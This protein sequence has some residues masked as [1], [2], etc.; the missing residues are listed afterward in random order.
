M[1]V[2]ERAH[3]RDQMLQVAARLFSERGY[4]G[5]SMQDL[6]EDLGMLR[7]SLYAHIESKE[8]LLFHIV[9]E[10][11]DRFIARMSEVA[12]S[13]SDPFEKLRAGLLA[14]ITTVAEHLDA[15]T[16]F[17][18]DWR[19]L[20]PA[21]KKQ[22]GKKRSRYEQLVSSIIEEGIK[23]GSFRNDLDPRFAALTFLSTV[24]WLYQWYDPKG[25]LD[26]AGIADKFSEIL[27]NGF[28]PHTRQRSHR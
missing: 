7:G 20:S 4:H 2:T 14:H 10:G 17:L 5:T 23:S 15:S 6:A 18:N 9:D 11:A 27:I 8:D 16:V 28:A 25:P 21:R 3:R 13:D 19:L 1:A 26:A 12:S 22:I 24:N